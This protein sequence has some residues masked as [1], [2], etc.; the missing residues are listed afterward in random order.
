MQNV[1]ITAKAQNEFATVKIGQ[2]EYSTTNTAKA[3]IETQADT[4]KFNIT[5]KAE[6]GEENTYEITINKVTDLG[7]T[8]IK[9]NDVECEKENGTYITYIDKGVTEVGLTIVPNNPIALVSTK[10]GTDDFSKAEANNTH[11]INIP[12]TKEETTI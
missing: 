10:V 8:S 12:I 3:T 6:N 11:I 1:E 4:Q 9:A 7:I 5:V 2:N